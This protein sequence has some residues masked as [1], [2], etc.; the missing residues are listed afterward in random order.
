M[1]LSS[2]H[3]SIVCYYVRINHT[4]DI[5]IRRGGERGLI[6]KQPLHDLCKEKLK[7]ETNVMD[8]WNDVL[9]RHFSADTFGVGTKDRTSHTQVALK[10][11]TV[12]L[13]S[14][15]N[16]NDIIQRDMWQLK[17][18]QTISQGK[19]W[20]ADQHSHRDKKNQQM[21]ITLPLKLNQ[22]QFTKQCIEGRNGWCSPW[23]TATKKAQN[24]S[25]GNTHLLA[26]PP[27]PR[28]QSQP[29]QEA[30][31]KSPSGVQPPTL[32]NPLCSE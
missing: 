22:G 19:Q 14:D 16:L 31:G 1:S 4:Q 11:E 5:I 3:V 13:E 12:D 29:C 26:I 28:N 15:W 18:P 20:D 17:G 10:A 8:H 24:R 25:Q 27:A 30:L 21:P 2:E 32:F 7:K 23:P 6:L 9:C